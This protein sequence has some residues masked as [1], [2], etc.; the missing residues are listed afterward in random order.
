M[1]AID[2]GT[3]RRGGQESIPVGAAKAGCLTLFEI[4]A[5][6]WSTT[7]AWLEEEPQAKINAPTNAVVC[8]NDTTPKCAVTAPD[9]SIRTWAVSVP[10]LMGMPGAA[11]MRDPIPVSSQ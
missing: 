10:V 1:E 5:A 8:P 6:P 4:G 3:V 11:E 2:G 7:S 9:E